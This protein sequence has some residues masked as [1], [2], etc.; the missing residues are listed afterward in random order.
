MRFVQL[1]ARGHEVGF[2]ENGGW[3]HLS[4]RFGKVSQPFT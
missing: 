2:G 4:T 3:D 1:H